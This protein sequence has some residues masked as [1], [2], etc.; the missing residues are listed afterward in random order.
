MILHGF[1][2]MAEHRDARSRLC[3]K[4]GMQRNGTARAGKKSL[5]CPPPS[6]SS[7]KGIRFKG[8]S[9]FREH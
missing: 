8:A 2:R 1:G 6:L 3:N 4:N 7:A 9:R 5:R